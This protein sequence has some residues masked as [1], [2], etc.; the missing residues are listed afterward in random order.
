MMRYRSFL[1]A[2][3]FVATS[4]QTEVNYQSHISIKT[5]VE[6]FV[7][8]KLQ[9]QHPH[10]D[11]SDIHIQVSNLDP[12]LKLKNCTEGLSSSLPRNKAIN[13][14]ITVKMHCK[15]P[16][17]WSI[18]IPTQVTV[19]D[20]VAV[21]AHSLNRGIILTKADLKLL[22][23]DISRAGNGH[24]RDLG[25]IIG[26]ELKR[27]VRANQV[28]QINQVRPPKIVNRGDK[29]RLEATISG[30]SVVTA[31][32]ALNSGGLG[33]QIQVRN[34]QSQKVV[35]ATVVGPGKVRVSL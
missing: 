11:A 14:K 6:G 29:I 5:T 33:E 13:A 18:Y 10:I 30:L 15:G 32:K 16:H 8:Q 17:P 34:I 12:R 27:S 26:Q 22:K 3:I 23:V 1:L 4:A 7:I 31:A 20:Q 25:R 35:Y 21:A 28:I 9:Q 24:I 2:L 19:F